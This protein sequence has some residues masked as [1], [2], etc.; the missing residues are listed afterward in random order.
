MRLGERLARAIHD[1]LNP[2]LRRPV[3]LSVWEDLRDGRILAIA[4]WREGTYQAET[5]WVDLIAQL[6]VAALDF[7]TT[8]TEIYLESRRNRP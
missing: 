8:L 6:E 2:R 5:S 4:E 1:F 3:K 7:S